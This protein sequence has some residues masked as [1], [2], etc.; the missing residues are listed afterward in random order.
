MAV[1]TRTTTLALP[2]K[3]ALLLAK[4]AQH[5]LSHLVNLA[6][7]AFTF[8]I[9]FVI[10]PVQLHFTQMA[11]SVPHA[12]VFALPVQLLQSVPPVKQIIVYITEDA[13]RVVQ[14][15]WCRWLGFV[16]VVQRVARLV[17]RLQICVQVAT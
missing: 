2:A 7:Q 3:I 11:L 17:K 10:P 16:Q 14:A 13:C 4:P 15:V 5:H 1:V 6:K 9:T 12:K 8:I